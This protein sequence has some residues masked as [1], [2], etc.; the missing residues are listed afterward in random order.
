MQAFRRIFLKLPSNAKYGLR[1]CA[2][3]NIEHKESDTSKISPP[4][5]ESDTTKISPPKKESD[6][7]KISPPNVVSRWKRFVHYI[8][9]D[10]DFFQASLTIVSTASIF[11]LAGYSYAR[12]IGAS[13]ERMKDIET[14]AAVVEKD[15]ETKVALMKKDFETSLALSKALSK[16]ELEKA[17]MKRKLVEDGVESAIFKARVE[18]IAGM[19]GTVAIALLLFKR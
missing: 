19:V 16:A 18:L 10:K 17:D 12:S 3:S 14:K 4:N 2:L 6:T 5:K 9:E 7:T 8:V 15:F 11:I 1:S 13:Y